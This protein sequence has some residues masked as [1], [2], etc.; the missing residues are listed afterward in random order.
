M[1]RKFL[2]DM[3]E[4]D[5]MLHK[6]LARYRKG[7]EPR[8]PPGQGMLIGFLMKNADKEIFQKDIEAEFDIARSTV[9]ATLDSM[10]RKGYI[11]REAVERDARLKKITLTQKAVESHNR[12][13]ADLE[14]LERAMFKNISAEEADTLFAIMD[15]IKEN[16]S[17]LYSK[18]GKSDGN[19]DNR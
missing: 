11:T 7:K 4:V 6:V 5:N 1:A 13:V 19:Q 12:I 9:T 15:K 18:G 2:R 8:V 16:L 17:N 3:R 10:E 14:Q